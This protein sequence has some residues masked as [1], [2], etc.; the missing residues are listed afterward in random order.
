MILI[1][2]S[3]KD[4]HL[5]FVTKH[6]TSEYKIID[7]DL[8]L[9][10]KGLTFSFSPKLEI[11]FDGQLIQDVKSVWLRKPNKPQSLNMNVRPE[12]KEYA[13]DALQRHFNQLYAHFGEAFWLSDNYVGRRASNKTL[14]LVVA[15]ELGL[16]IPKTIFTSDKDIAQS[17]VRK[18]RDAV[19]K[20]IS[21]VWPAAEGRQKAFF[22]R[23]ISSD[24]ETNYNGLNL[25][26]AIFQQAI[27]PTF[28]IRVTV[29]GEKIFAAKII[30]ENSKDHEVLDWRI[31]HAR[32]RGNLSFS[33]YE[34]PQDI[35]TKCIQ[36]TKRLGLKFG[37]IDLVHGEDGIWFLEINPNGQWAFVEEVTGQPIGK[38]IA[39]LL[40]GAISSKEY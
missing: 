17:F 13:Q 22:T 38:A 20:G 14:Q 30:L 37:A 8:I 24:R 35:A 36:L 6:L 27:K 2:S 5:P 26:P 15:G 40:E 10:G 3:P 31:G 21:V 7:P 34:L 25:A 11:I 18:Q 4:A 39:D 1:I 29:V 9:K 16:R 23:L 32:N 19:V 28:D 12:Y 33:A